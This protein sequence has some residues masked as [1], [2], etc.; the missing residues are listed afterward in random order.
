MFTHCQQ[1]NTP[2]QASQRK[3]KF[4]S[5]KCFG[6]SKRSD[7][8]DEEVVRLHTQGLSCAGIGQMV[9]LTAMSIWN[10]LRRQ[11]VTLSK[12]R[13]GSKNSMFGRTH[14]IE[15]R[16]KIRAAT[17][18]QFA[19]PGMR[20]AAAQRTIDQIKAGR[21]GKAFNK[22]EQA[23]AE[24]LTKLQI[25]FEPQFQLKTFVFDFKIKDVPILIEAQGT[26]WHADPRFYSESKSPIQRRNCNN[27]R[28]KAT[29][30]EKCGYRIIYVW[31]HDV[32][33]TPD[34]VSNYLRGAIRG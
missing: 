23:V 32:K 19:K 1:C 6:V 12:S 18:R 20:E 17:N 21:T 14:T 16:E 7:V 26:F 33:T 8:S 2:L 24:I 22:L 5:R 31:E 4:C 3:N 10:R 13:S 11:G 30:A 9:G 27:D 28:A 15:S 25:V 29:L 34:L